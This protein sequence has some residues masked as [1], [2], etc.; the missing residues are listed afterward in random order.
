MKYYYFSSP[1]F[2]GQ[3]YKNQTAILSWLQG[4]GHKVEFVRDYSQGPRPEPAPRMMSGIP[5]IDESKPPPG[6][7]VRTSVSPAGE[8]IH[9]VGKPCP[10]CSCEMTAVGRHQATRDHKH[11]RSKGGTLGKRNKIVVCARCNNDKGSLTLEK[12][13]ERLKTAG[14][15]RAEKVGWVL[16]DEIK[17]RGHRYQPPES[18]DSQE[19]A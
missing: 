4:L 3:I 19:S 8:L 15:P 6:K 14:D 11:P 2:A 10:Y 9:H 16:L 7:K 1:L 5:V 12:W 13:L 17:G 18:A